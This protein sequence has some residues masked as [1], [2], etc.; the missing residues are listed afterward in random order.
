MKNIHFI[1]LMALIYPSMVFATP[2]YKGQTVNNKIIDCNQV[3]INL[4]TNKAYCYVKNSKGT[5]VSAGL[6]TLKLWTGLFDSKGTPIYEGDTIS[7]PNYP[8]GVVTLGSASN[9]CVEGYHGWYV[10]AGY[11]LPFLNLGNYSS[12]YWSTVVR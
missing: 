5:L 7:T 9:L 4:D 8:T 12:I 2:L 10:K 6:V 3:T 11:N 1:F